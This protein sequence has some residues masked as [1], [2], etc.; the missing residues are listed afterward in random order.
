[1]LCGVVVSSW[2]EGVSLVLLLLLLLP[3]PGCF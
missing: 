2:W 3:A 1:M